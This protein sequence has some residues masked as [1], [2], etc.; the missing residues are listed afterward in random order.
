MNDYIY[1]VFNNKFQIWKYKSFVYIFLLTQNAIKYTVL[2]TSYTFFLF[3]K[4]IKMFFSAADV[5]FLKRNAYKNTMEFSSTYV[6]KTQHVMT[7][8]IFFAEKFYWP[9]FFFQINGIKS[10][11]HFNNFRKEKIMVQISIFSFTSTAK[12][13]CCI[14]LYFNEF[15][16]LIW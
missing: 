9:T 7:E 1:T 5:D 12:Y 14:N 16:V 15:N 10:H 13:L 8:I 4:I 11:K 3:L 6:W 2:N